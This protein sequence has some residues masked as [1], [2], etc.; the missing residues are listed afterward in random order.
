MALGVYCFNWTQS[1]RS[2]SG[3]Y[4]EGAVVPPL[5]VSSRLRSRW[6]LRTCDVIKFVEAVRS[7]PILP[8]AKYRMTTQSRSRAAIGWRRR[9]RFLL[10]ANSTRDNRSSNAGKSIRTKFR[11]DVSSVF[12]KSLNSL[13]YAPHT[14]LSII[15]DFTQTER[16]RSWECPVI[17]RSTSRPLVINI[18]K[19]LPERV[20]SSVDPMH[21]I[22]RPLYTSVICSQH[23]IVCRLHA[24]LLWPQL[25]AYSIFLHVLFIVFTV[26]YHLMPYAYTR[27]YITLHLS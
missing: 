26:N 18:H 12:N 6:V 16:R 5:N 2:L 25:N 14:G 7:H 21:T 19:W 13:L 23:T 11:N 20:C 4:N 10:S 17:D 24:S 8:V 22:V 3:S 27:S 15:Q 1:S 9:V